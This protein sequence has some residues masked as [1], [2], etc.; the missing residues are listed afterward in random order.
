MGYA[1]KL[2]RHAIVQ[3]QETIAYISKVLL[4]PETA[5]AWSDCLQ[6]EI[7][8]LDTM[9]SRFAS[10][11]EEPW[12]FRG[13]RKMPVKNFIVYYYVNEENKTVWVTAVVYG[14]RDQ[15]NVLKK[16]SSKP[17]MSD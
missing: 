6:K 7:T 15:L 2:T 9:P 17:K 5:R 1:V 4:E 8:G 13:F 16:M 14:L 3:I 10:V 11:D 12:R